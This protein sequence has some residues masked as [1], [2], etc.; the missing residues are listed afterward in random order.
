MT[1]ISC[2][3][4]CSGEL[5]YRLTVNCV[6]VYVCG[7]RRIGVI[8]GALLQLRTE[9]HLDCQQTELVVSALPIGALVASLTGGLSV[10]PSVCYS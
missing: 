1:R 10:C 7:I 3:M 9:F 2:E 5:F 6:S 8:S 4:T